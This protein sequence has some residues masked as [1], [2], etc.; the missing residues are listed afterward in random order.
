MGKEPTLILYALNAGVSA[1]QVAAIPMPT[2]AHAIAL[3]V[4]GA[5]TALVNRQSVTP[6]AKIGA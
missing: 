4:S 6:N 3:G 1:A 5:L 2:W